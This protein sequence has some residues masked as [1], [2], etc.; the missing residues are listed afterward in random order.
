MKYLKKFE[1]FD[2]KVADMKHTPSSR[3]QLGL[4]KND[5]EAFQNYLTNKDEES[6]VCTKCDCIPCQCTGE[7][8]DEDLKEGL[9]ENFTDWRVNSYL[10]IAREKYNNMTSDEVIDK[11]ENGPESM[12][13]KNEEEKNLFKEKWNAEKKE[14]TFAYYNA[15]SPEELR[16]LQKTF[17]HDFDNP[18]QHDPKFVAYL[19]ACELKKVFVGKDHTPRNLKQNKIY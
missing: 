18:A 2:V 15:M 8:Y 14:G 19:K 6:E 11:I 5:E 3:K 1:M 7:E 4:D 10:K 17:K 13:F 9:E 12:R 16:S